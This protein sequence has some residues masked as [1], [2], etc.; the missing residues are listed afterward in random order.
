MAHDVS[1]TLL[2]RIL[3]QFLAM[4]V[5]FYGTGKAATAIIAAAVAATPDSLAQS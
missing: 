5:Q 3:P 1:V 4:I 2:W